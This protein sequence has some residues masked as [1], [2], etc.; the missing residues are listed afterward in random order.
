MALAKSHSR[1]NASGFSLVEVT[2]AT[3]LLA[4][5]LMSLAQL[6]AMSVQSNTSSRDMTFATVLAQQKL[7]QLRALAWGFDEIGLPVSDMTTNT[8]V[9]PEDPFSGTGLTPSP[10][11]A[12]LGNVQGYHDFVDQWGNTVGF[13]DEAMYFRRWSVEPLP[14]NPNNTL[15]L[16]VVVGRVR[17]RGLAEGTHR[18]IRD[19]AR[20]MTVKTRKSR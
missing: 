19:E 18:R 7:E 11:D 14:T 13:S 2:V 10:G 20:V 4:A 1:N 12:L 16:Q 5:A 17:D 15:V 3:G 9:Q 6:F 8:A